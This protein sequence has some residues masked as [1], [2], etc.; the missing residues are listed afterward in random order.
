MTCLMILKAILPHTGLTI[1]CDSA[2]YKYIL[3]YVHIPGNTATPMNITNHMFKKKSSANHYFKVNKRYANR[4][5]YT[6]HSIRFPPDIPHRNC[7]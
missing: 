7:A 3:I 2:H 6:Q 5:E 1:L 4:T